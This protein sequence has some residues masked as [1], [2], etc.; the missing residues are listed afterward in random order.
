LRICSAHFK[1]GEK[2]E[3]D[4]P[5]ADPQVDPPISI[6]LPPKELRSVVRRN[7]TTPQHLI[8]ETTR[9]SRYKR[10]SIRFG[11]EYR[12]LVNTFRGREGRREGEREMAVEVKGGQFF[13]CVFEWG[14]KESKGGKH[15]GKGREGHEGDRGGEGH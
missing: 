14:Q 11:T 3:G 2:R 13:A 4:I 9:K 15:Y 1:G 12:N 6:A 5:V 7:P 10:R 8:Q